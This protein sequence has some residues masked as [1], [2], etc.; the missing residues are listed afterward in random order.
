MTNSNANLPVIVNPYLCG[1]NH[2][3]FYRTLG[4]EESRSRLDSYYAHFSAEEKSEAVEGFKDAYYCASEYNE[5]S[6]PHSHERWMRVRDFFN[7]KKNNEP[8]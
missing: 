7:G 3:I 4:H 5:D 6:E 2:A 8:N 1:A